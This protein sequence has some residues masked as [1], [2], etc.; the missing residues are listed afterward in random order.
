MNHFDSLAVLHIFVWGIQV[1][2]DIMHYGQYFKIIQILVNTQNKNETV[3]HADPNVR[4][5]LEVNTC[6]TFQKESS[7]W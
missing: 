3:F 1:S 7:P 5:G 2:G 4:V 6:L